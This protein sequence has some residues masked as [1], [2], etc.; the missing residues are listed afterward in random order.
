MTSKTTNSFSLKKPT[1]DNFIFYFFLATLIWAPI[2]LESNRAWSEILLRILISCLS[3]LWSTLYLLNKTTLTNSF[4]KAL[5]VTILFIASQVFLVYQIVNDISIDNYS[6]QKELIL[7][8]NLVFIFALSLVLL[9]TSKRIKICIYVIVF[10]GLFQALY[11]S[12][13]TLT[14]LEYTFFLKKETYLGVATGTFINRNHLAGYLVICLSL[15]LGMMV[16]TLNSNADNFKNFLRQVSQAILSKKLILRISLIIMV[17]ALVMTHSR[18]GNTAF[19]VSMGVIGTL[20]ILLKKR[21]VGSTIILLVSL[22]IIDITVVGTFFGV[23]KVINRL[24]NTSA[25][26]ETRDEVNQY[27]IKIIE[28][29]L[30]FGT[31]AGPLPHRFPTST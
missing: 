28:K 12:L 5:P 16:A 21:S 7:G 9:N 18:M 20:A 2:P 8:I 25:K 23:D 19:F 6:T 22:I 14:G 31:G 27:S 29:N 4:K 13:M 11:G 10:S 26:K 3:L 17:V 15:G 1:H 30:Y 24:E